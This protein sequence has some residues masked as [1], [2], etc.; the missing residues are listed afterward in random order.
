[1]SNIPLTTEQLLDKAFGSNT[2]AGTEVQQALGANNQKPTKAIGVNI[3]V[4][5]QTKQQ[6]EGSTLFLGSAFSIDVGFIE[7]Y[8]FDKGL[9]QQNGDSIKAQI[10]HLS[11]QRQHEEFSLMKSIA[12]SMLAN[13]VREYTINWDEVDAEKYPFTVRTWKGSGMTWHFVNRKLSRPSGEKLT[14]S[15]VVEVLAQLL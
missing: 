4:I 7:P 11:I 13:S 2:N 3:S 15:K 12:D 5:T 6:E 10:F 8:Q 9:P 14:S 1:M